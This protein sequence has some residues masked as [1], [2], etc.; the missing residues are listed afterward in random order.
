MKPHDRAIVTSSKSPNHRTPK[1]LIEA[2]DPLHFAFVI[3]VAATTKDHIAGVHHY[4]GPDQKREEWRDALAP[5]L[6]WVATFNQ[7]YAGQPYA[8]WMN[9]PWSREQG[10]P[11]EP[12]VERASA[13]GRAGIT[14]VALLPAAIQTQ[15]WG[16]LVWNKAYEVRLFPHRL[17]FDDAEG[18]QQSNANFNSALVIWKSLDGF[19]KGFRTH[20]NYWTYR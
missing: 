11:I 6:D 12:W 15:W 8:L 17:S 19:K 18:Q 9:P 20:V 2:L 7:Y 1:S 10:M 5:S 14:T 13:A 4:F 3:D 16:D